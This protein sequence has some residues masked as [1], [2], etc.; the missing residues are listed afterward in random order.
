MQGRWWLAALVLVL[1][2]SAGCGN[3]DQA[4]LA[5]SPAGPVERPPLSERA[6]TADNVAQL[7]EVRRWIVSIGPVEA[8]AFS[9]TEQHRLASLGAD[10]VLRVWDVDTGR[11]L[12]EPY[13]H[14]GVGMGVAFSPDGSRLVSGGRA[15]GNDLVLLDLESGAVL[16]NQGLTGYTVY[17][18]QWSPD[19]SRF[20]VV[21]RG[22]SRVFIYAADGASLTQ[23][24]PSGQ[25][26]WSVAYG[27][28]WLAVTNE[29]GAVFVFDASTYDLRREF[30][31]GPLIAGRDL[32]FSADESLLANCYFDG[33]VRVWRTE[34]WSLAAEFTAHQFALD[35]GILGC[36]DAAFGRGGD[37]YFTVGDD[38]W[39]RAWNPLTGQQVHALEFG[40]NIWTVSVSGD[41]ELL[42]VTLLD[43][44]LHVLGLPATAEALG[45]DVIGS[46]GK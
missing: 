33:N 25:W 35:R 37:L 39:L 29:M 14:D 42:A 4:D 17:D 41:G 44:T 23:R 5:L 22:S 36:R 9:P 40:Q 21:S 43:G 7:R 20:A 26:L 8:A 45:Q 12:A 18:V 19:G 13:E 1:A 6:I 2:G 34:D 27:S 38:G 10:R 24:R 30:E 32:E 3:S 28:R 31:Y 15:G 46:R 11:L 16:A